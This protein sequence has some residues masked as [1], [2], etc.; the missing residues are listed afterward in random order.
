MSYDPPTG[1]EL[2]LT[3]SA[4]KAIRRSSAPAADSAESSDST[5]L[6]VAST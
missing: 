3:R 6:D 1:P 2:L 4:V 5:G